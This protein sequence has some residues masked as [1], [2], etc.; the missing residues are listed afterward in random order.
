MVADLSFD[1]IDELS[2]AR[3]TITNL[4]EKLDQVL[5][6]IPTKGSAPK[7]PG[8]VPCAMI[9]IEAWVFVHRR[10]PG[11]KNERVQ[12][13]CDEYWQSC[14]CQSL[15]DPENWRRSLAEALKDR[16]ALRR[17]QCSPR[18]EQPDQGAPDQPA[19]IAHRSNYQPIRGRQSA[20][21]G[22]R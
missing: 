4:N 11:A 21:L 5:A 15:G 3:K 14:G 12:E 13:L 18:P 19:K 1:F 16:S 8:R 22:L 17:F 6:R 2:S 10:Q 20:V 7:K 9:V